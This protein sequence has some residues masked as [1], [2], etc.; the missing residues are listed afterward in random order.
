[1][2]VFLVWSGV[3]LW[4]AEEISFRELPVSLVLLKQT[5][6]SRDDCDAIGQKLGGKIEHL[7][8]AFLKV[9]GATIQANVIT[10]ADGPSASAI[11]ASLLKMKPDPFC[12]RRGNQVV[13]YV[14]ANL[15]EG[16]AR[17]TSYE[18]GFVPKPSRVNYQIEAEVA[19]VDRADYMSCNLLFT[20]FLKLAAPG[21]TPVSV[22]IATI[23]RQFRFGRS[24]VLRNRKLT[25][26]P[27]VVTE[28]RFKD[29][30]MHAEERGSGTRYDFGDP[31]PFRVGIPF[32]RAVFHLPVSDTGLSKDPA[33]PLSRLT[34]ATEHWP[35]NDSGIVA[36]AEE[37]TRGKRD[38]ESKVRAILEWLTPGRNIKYSGETGSRWG[39]QKVFKQR[40]G[41]C[42]DFSDCFVV[43]SRASGV[44][45]R[46][47][48]G[49]LYGTSGHV[50]AEYY[51]EGL[52]WQQVDPTGGG[53]LECGIY[54]IP[55]FTTDDGEMPI[56]Y[57]SMPRIT[58]ETEIK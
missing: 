36:L 20:E 16:L 46:Q 9:H 57:L 3:T 8:N 43:L 14:G 41:H 55:Y 10:A 22:S 11:H 23:A 47:V 24:L 33:K 5:E 39:A 31:L 52:G 30:P 26:V 15:D 50:W 51:R 44:P 45:A 35:A 21:Q 56:V 38:N 49:W 28:Y 13:E 34:A 58:A 6:A 12:V 48:A 2:G 19:L 53:V 54:H 42:W 27:E 1:M 25:T 40:F 7:T 17:K 37:I 29:L 4:A 18:L 32:V